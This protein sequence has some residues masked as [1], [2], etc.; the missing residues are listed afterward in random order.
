MMR[1]RERATGLAPMTARSLD[2]A[3]DGQAADVA[4]RKD[5]GWTTKESVV[6]QRRPAMAG[7]TAP[8]VKGIRSPLARPRNDAL[9]DQALHE[10]PSPTVA[11]RMV[12]SSGRAA[13]LTAGLFLPRT[14]W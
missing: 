7:K 6:K 2:R 12:S 10:L 1:P 11:R 4:A 3:A 8:S 5:Q 9:P 13:L 14:R